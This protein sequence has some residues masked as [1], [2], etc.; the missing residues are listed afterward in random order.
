M[1][2]VLVK[3]VTTKSHMFT[4]TLKAG[5]SRHTGKC[6]ANQTRAAATAQ[7]PEKRRVFLQLPETFK[8]LV[9]NFCFLEIHLQRLHLQRGL[10]HDV[11]PLLMQ[12]D[13]EQGLLAASS[14]SRRALH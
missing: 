11:W 1:D 10:H 8:K 14:E 13:R 9:W 6:P 4:D 12:N 3:L 7:P 2:R 5:I